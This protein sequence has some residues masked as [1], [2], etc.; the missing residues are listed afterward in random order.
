MRAEFIT[1][2]EP[3]AQLRE[4][5]LNGGTGSDTLSGGEGRDTPYWR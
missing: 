4:Q 3:T 2:E 1:F 5:G